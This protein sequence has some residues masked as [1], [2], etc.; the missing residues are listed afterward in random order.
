[1]AYSD[2]VLADSPLAY[3]RL[4]ESSGTTIGD[5][6]GNTR[7][8]TYAGTYTLG[9]TGLLGGDS[10]TAVSATSGVG[11]VTAASWMNVSGAVSLE[12]W[13]KTT[14]SGVLGL[15]GRTNAGTWGESDTNTARI[16]LN[17]GTLVF[18]VFSSSWTPAFTLQTTTTYHEGI[19]HHV[20]GT[21][22]GSTA[23][24]YVD[25]A[26]VVSTSASFTMA[27]SSSLPFY[28][29]KMAGFFSYAGTLDEVAYYSTALSS[30]RVGAHFSAGGTINLTAQIEANYLEA[31]ISGVPMAQVE[32]N[33]LE[34]MYNNPT[35]QV[36]TVY[37]EA[38]GY[39]ASSAVVETVYTEALISSPRLQ[40][41]SVYAEVI[42][43]GT[44]QVQAE[45][46]YAE[47]L[48]SGTPQVRAEMVYAEV[49]V[50]L[51]NFPNLQRG[52]GVPIVMT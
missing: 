5:S 6:S 4:G 22:D 33:Y 11:S 40:I 45:S 12:C 24:L 17:N 29:G 43:S 23:V 36:E 16:Y 25:G 19:R 3:W 28:L 18:Q 39:G 52:W 1:M 13:F 50:S 32:S 2:E 10:D 38:L 15:I 14:T 51:V 49:L 47:V 48:A 44:P 41:E 26:S 21:W 9:A 31:L 20:V 35:A 7:D 42:A 37:L 34:V 8:G 27:S 46:V 30:T